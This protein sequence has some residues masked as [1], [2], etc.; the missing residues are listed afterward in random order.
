MKKV[1]NVKG[2]KLSVLSIH[3]KQTGEPFSVYAMDENGRESLFIEKSQSQ[4]DTRPHI[5]VENLSELLE[6]PEIDSKLAEEREKL[7][8]HLEELY[9]RESSEL[10][11]LSTKPFSFKIK[12]KRVAGLFDAIEEVK[13]FHEG[14]REWGE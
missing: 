5:A 2:T 11:K 13:A 9:E 8:T 14:Y 4:Y 10:T 3:Y 6:Y 1:L 12:E 7:I